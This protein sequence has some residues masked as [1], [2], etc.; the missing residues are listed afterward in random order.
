MAKKILSIIAGIIFSSFLVLGTQLNYDHA[1]KFEFLTLVELFIVGLVIGLFSYKLFGL[2]IK[3][4]TDKNYVI[5]W[6]KIFIPLMILSLFLLFVIYPGN[7]CYDSVYQYNIYK[8][9]G[10]DTHYPVIF[11]VI[12]GAFLDFGK[13]VFGNFEIG[14]FFLVFLQSFFINFVISKII[15]YLSNKIKNKKFTIISVLFFALHLPLQ[16]LILSSC[17]DVI[18]GGF[19]A[20]L[21]LEFL[22]MTEENNYF[23]KKSNFVKVGFITLFMCLFRNNGFFALIP[24]IIISYIFLKEHRKQFLIMLAIPTIIFQGWNVF[25]K[26]NISVDNQSILHESL[27]VPIMQ[28]AR[29]VNYDRDNVYTKDLWHFFG[30][31]CDWSAYK[32]YPSNSDRIKFCLNDTNLK[33]NFSKFI[34]LYISIGL[35]SPTNYIEAPGLLTLGLYYPWTTYPE[36]PFN[37]SPIY[38]PYVEHAVVDFTVYHKKGTA[39]IHRYPNIPFLNDI[40]EKLLDNNEWT[41][42]YGFRLIWCGAFITFLTIICILFSFYKKQYKLLIPLSLIIGLTITIFLAPVVLFRYIFPIVL[43][44][45]IM[46]Y[47]LIVA[48]KSS[49][50]QK[51]SIK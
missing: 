2:K 44:A 31:L 8:S 23:S 42:L 50:H 19:F 27:N 41:K 1:I 13:N 38:H 12:L 48:I 49:S 21:V 40:I 6:Q 17:H 5:K 7:Y 46:L 51:S 39:D 24:A 9:G 10:F 45:P 22:K 30:P 18:F 47:I 35:K 36:D 34:D 20:L 43:T 14:L 32:K 16:I 11:C 29:A 28:I 37:Q 33:K 4:K 25:Y 26:N 15:E 3:L